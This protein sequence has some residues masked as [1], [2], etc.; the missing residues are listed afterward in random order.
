M[1]TIIIALIS[2]IQFILEMENV[3]FIN[4]NLEGLTLKRRAISS[5]MKSIPFSS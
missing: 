3:R 2:A 1:P 4:D 5:K